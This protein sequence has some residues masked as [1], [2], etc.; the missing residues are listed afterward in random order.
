MDIQNSET[1]RHLTQS[2]QSD[3]REAAIEYN[4]RLEARQEVLEDHNRRLEEQLKKL[5]ELLHQVEA[6]LQSE[7]NRA[8][9]KHKNR[10]YD[11]PGSEV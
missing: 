10:S 9:A 1:R 11:L 3:E 8:H 4:E 2:L 6:T 7:K 5:R